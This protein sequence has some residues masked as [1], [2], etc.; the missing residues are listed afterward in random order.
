MTGALMAMIASFVA[1]AYVAKMS[2]EAVIAHTV[3][4][5]QTYAAI[6]RNGSV[7]W[8][9]NHGIFELVALLSFELWALVLTILGIVAAVEV[10]NMVEAREQGVKEEGVGGTPW[11]AREA[12]K[13]FTMEMIIGLGAVIGGYCLG[14]VADKLITWFDEYSDNTDDEGTA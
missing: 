4:F 2:V 1:A 12:F 9:Y 8:G 7:T 3:A 13:F 6:Y 10:W 14:D 11:D 5:Q